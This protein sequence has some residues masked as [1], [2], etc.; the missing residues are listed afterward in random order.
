MLSNLSGDS[1]DDCYNVNITLDIDANGNIIFPY[2]LLSRL[3]V[4]NYPITEHKIGIIM[5]SNSITKQVGLTTDQVNLDLTPFT[6]PKKY[7]RN[8]LKLESIDNEIEID[9]TGL[10]A[11]ILIDAIN[12]QRPLDWILNNQDRLQKVSK[13]STLLSNGKGNNFYITYNEFYECKTRYNLPSH[14]LDFFLCGNKIYY[15]KRRKWKSDSTV[16]PDQRWIRNIENQ[17]PFIML[18]PYGPTLSN[19]W[20]N[21]EDLEHQHLLY[22]VAGH[23]LFKSH[24]PSEIQLQEVQTNIV[25]LVEKR[26]FILPEVPYRKLQLNAIKL[27]SIRL[28][29]P[30][31]TTINNRLRSIVRYFT[32]DEVTQLIDRLARLTTHE[33]HRV[34]TRGNAGLVKALCGY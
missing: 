21:M 18:K 7:E 29:F 6:E 20:N 19:D 14:W 25:Q 1:S 3:E 34:I 26:K 8:F 28:N 33:I 9:E 30:E 31:V 24:R 12:E 27:T 13:L 11:T 4:T 32:K 15:F 5:C 17:R 2:S 16:T 10:M 22:L 23:S